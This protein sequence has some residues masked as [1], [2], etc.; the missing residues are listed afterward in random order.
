M[1]SLEYLVC[2][3]AGSRSLNKWETG[4][5][6]KP[7]AMDACG[8]LLQGCTAGLETGCETDTSQ[9]CELEQIVYLSVPQFPHLEIENAMFC[10]MLGL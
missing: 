3:G 4:S 2:P 6:G 8:G 5:L 1:S 9:L 7:G 10:C